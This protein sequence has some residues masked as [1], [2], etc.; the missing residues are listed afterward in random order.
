[1]GCK[2]WMQ[3]ITISNFFFNIVEQYIE[4]ADESM[5]G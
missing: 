2:E 3:E 4:G 5:S 1:M